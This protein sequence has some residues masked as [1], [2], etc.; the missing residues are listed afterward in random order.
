MSNNGTTTKQVTHS[1]DVDKL[2][3]R[4]ERALTIIDE[5]AD[6]LCEL[7]GLS[8]D[9][10]PELRPIFDDGEAYRYRSFNRENASRRIEKAAWSYM[11]RASGAWTFMDAEAR[12]QWHE[13][14]EKGEFPP[15]TREAIEHA[16]ANLH[17]ERGTMVT[18]GV[19]NV[20]DSLSRHHK[21]NSKRAFGPKLIVEYVL[22]GWGSPSHS[23]ASLFDDL[24]RFL[25][26]LRGLPEPEHETKSAYCE[27]SDAKREDRLAAFPFFV[28]KLFK[29]G[30][31]HVVFKHDS[32]VQALNVCLAAATG[33]V[34]LAAGE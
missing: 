24:N 27:I 6:K 1:C 16:F 32:D 26:L 17:D 31:G 10:I 20:F 11:V 34:R 33:G 8:G 15:M 4:R 28:I 22:N 12:K 19:A 3:G 18:R 14:Y 30:N 13:T 2:L 25:H 29:N 23:R 7:R 9:G 21:T 5:I